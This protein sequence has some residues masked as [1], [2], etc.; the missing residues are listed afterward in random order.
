MR[1]SR[2]SLGRNRRRA[3]QPRIDD[4][5][6][7]SPLQCDA[8]HECA[9]VCGSEQQIDIEFDV[10]RC[11]DLAALSGGL[12]YGAQYAAPRRFHVGER[13]GQDLVML[14]GNERAHRRPERRTLEI[15]DRRAQHGDEIAPKRARSRRIRMRRRAEGTHGVRND[16]GLTGEAPIESLFARADARGHVIETQVAESA[17][18]EKRERCG[19]NPF[20]ESGVERTRCRHAG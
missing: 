8:T 17:L 1:A 7:R 2:T 6:R 16:F 4:P 18:R 12:E 5:F 14:L 3:V 11:V 9:R 19:A 13:A 10:A 15:A 20:R